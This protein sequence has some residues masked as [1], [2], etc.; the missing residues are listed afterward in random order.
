VC[1]PA[2]GPCQ[3]PRAPGGRPSR[4]EPRCDVPVIE[5]MTGAV[6]IVDRTG[7]I[8]AHN[9]EWSIFNAHP[10]RGER[11]DGV[12][13]REAWAASD[14]PG[15]RF[16]VEGVGALLSQTDPVSLTVKVS[17]PT[18]PGLSWM[19]VRIDTVQVRSERHL[20]L[21]HERIHTAPP[22]AAHSQA[23]HGEGH[24]HPQRAEGS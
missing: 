19:R 20:L 3:H 9:A 10:S 6:V 2:W 7:T 4:R 21:A 12:T 22:A 11:W 18:Q 15:A 8:V 14:H 23:P 24:R 5:S 1:R 13:Y 17:D 16:L